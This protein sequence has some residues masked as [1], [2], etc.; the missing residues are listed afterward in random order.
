MVWIVCL[1]AVAVTAWLAGVRPALAVAVITPLLLLGALQTSLGGALDWRS[2]PAQLL[3]GAAVY[4]GSAALVIAARGRL[5]RAERQA[6]ESRVRAQTAR[7]DAIKRI[8]SG[9]AHELRN[10]LGVVRNAAYL[11]RKRL[12]KYDVKPDLLDMID[13]EVRSAD[14]MITALSESISVRNPEPAYADVAVLARE[15]LVR[16]GGGGAIQ[17]SVEVA[18]DVGSIWCD[19]GQIQQVLEMLV[20]NAV[21]AM[22]GKGRIE[23]VARRAGDFDQIQVRDSGPGFSAE[24]VADVFEPLFTTKRGRSGLGLARCRQ[25]LDR[26]GG[27][28]EVVAGH[29]GGGAV[30]ISLPRKAVPTTAVAMTQSAPAAAI[31]STEKLVS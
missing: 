28:I 5:E 1:F 16:V 10:P 24:N 25:I 12:S 6:H 23:I 2:S 31:L 22:Q 3:A 15:A 20:Q 11:L 19:A 27:R 21:E 7:T 29:E 14:A 4:C 17:A 30:R 18:P 26:H 13:E 8:S 9:L